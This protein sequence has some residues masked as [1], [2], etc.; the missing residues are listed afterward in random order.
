MMYL[1]PSKNQVLL[2]NALVQ[3][4]IGMAGIRGRW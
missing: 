2:Q 3:R 4:L 1:E